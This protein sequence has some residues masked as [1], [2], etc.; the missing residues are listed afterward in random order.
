MTSASRVWLLMAL[1]SLALVACRG[2]TSAPRSTP[3]SHPVPSD[4]GRFVYRQYPLSISVCLDEC[5][6][7]YR[8]CRSL[9]PDCEALGQLQA[10]LHRGDVGAYVDLSRQVQLRDRA[11]VCIRTCG[12][13]WL[14]CRRRCFDAVDAGLLQRP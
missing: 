7:I 11:D 2:S 5:T 8:Q 10:A 12:E 13:P 6:R 3:P 14:L 9:T 1:A 4:A